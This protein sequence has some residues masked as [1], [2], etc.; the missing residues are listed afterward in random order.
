M[1][2]RVFGEIAGFPVGTTFPDRRGLHDSGIHRPLQGGISG[3]GREGADSIVV[4]GGYEDDRDFGDVIVYTSHG[5]NDPETGKQIA[6]QELTVRNLALAKSALDGLP[7]RVVRGAGGDPAYSPASGLRYDGLYFVEDYWQE[8][9]KSGFLIWRFRLV[10]EP[11]T[12]QPPAN[13]DAPAPAG[14]ALRID[15]LVQRLIRSTVLI[16]KIKELHDYRCQVCGE[17]IETSA[18]P[19]AEGAHIRP[20]GKPHDG[21]DVLEN[22]LCL[23]PNDHVRFDF[24]GIVIDDDLSVI[25]ADG[26]KIGALRTV[27]KHSVN[28]TYLKYHRRRFSPA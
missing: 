26:T 5:G 3:S 22:L 4:S 1:A 17:R 6:D 12:P 10:K 20:L 19:Y 8:K 24:G 18:G 27:P 14:P 25:N 16:Q 9:G 7:V 2:E 15:T 21:P 23:C 28:K 11:A 13:P